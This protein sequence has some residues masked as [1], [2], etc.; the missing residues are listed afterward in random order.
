LARRSPE[1]RE[2]AA[3]RA[4]ADRY[5]RSRERDA[6]ARAALQPLA[7]GERPRSLAIAALL[8]ALLAAANVVLLAAGWDIEGGGQSVAGALLFAALMASAAVGMWQ[9]RYW[10]VLGF[11]ALLGIAI[12]YASLALLVASNLEAVLRCVAIIAIAAPLFWSL[13]RVMARLQVPSRRPRE[14]VG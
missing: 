14:P 6:A 7:P 9:R 12:V 1:P 2:P 3:P 4:R 11:E 13:I 5:A 10:A 8:A